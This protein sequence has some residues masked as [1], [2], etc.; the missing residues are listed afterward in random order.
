MSVYKRYSDNTKCMYFI[1]KDGTNFD[2]YMTGWE[3][4]SNIIK[5]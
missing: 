1:I 2:N 3:K 5:N 4:V